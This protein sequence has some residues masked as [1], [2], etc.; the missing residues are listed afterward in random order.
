MLPEIETKPTLLYTGEE[1][2]LE[3]PLLKSIPALSPKHHILFW[4]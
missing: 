1:N 2:V 3:I 4:F